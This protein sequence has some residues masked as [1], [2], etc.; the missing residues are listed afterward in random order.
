M[1]LLEDSGIES[2]DKSS[3]VTEDPDM[4]TVSGRSVCC[5]EKRDKVY[6][7]MVWLSS[8]RVLD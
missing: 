3:F 2:E 7:F 5:L 4:D 8:H 1:P 6:E